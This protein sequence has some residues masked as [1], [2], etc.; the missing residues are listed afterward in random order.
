MIYDGLR[1]LTVASAEQTPFDR[2][3]RQRLNSER[4]P[5]DWA[6]TRCAS[7]GSAAPKVRD[8]VRDQC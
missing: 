8:V 1:Q 3:T 7:A 5:K 6:C 2:A 4:P